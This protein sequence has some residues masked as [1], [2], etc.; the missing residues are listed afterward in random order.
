MC[1]LNRR[2]HGAQYHTVSL[3][4]TTSIWETAES[5]QAFHWFGDTA[6]QDKLA[7][8]VRN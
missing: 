4:A 6:M 7:T 1:N 3:V 2:L 5:Y 8:L